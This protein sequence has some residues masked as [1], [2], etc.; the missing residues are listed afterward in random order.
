MRTIPLSVALLALACLARAG[1][2]AITLRAGLLLDGTGGRREMADVRVEGGRI[3][4]ITGPGKAV[5]THDLSG[6]T[7]LPGLIDAHDH[8]GWTFNDKGRLHT[9]DDG[10]SRER[11]ALGGAAN[12]WETLRSG[13]TTVQ[14]LGAP[15]DRDLRDAIAAGLPGPRILTSLEPLGEDTTVAPDALRALVR[16]RKAQGADVIKLF[17]SKSIRDG[18][19]A[20]LGDAQV[21]AVCG[22][23]KAVGLRSVVHAHAAD[24]MLAAARAGCTQVEHGVFATP[25]AL[26]EMAQRGTVFDP[27][28][29]LVFRN[30]LRHRAAYEGIGNYNAAGFALMETSIPISFIT[31]ARSS[32]CI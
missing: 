23:A 6:Y 18:G 20:S 9:E 5:P 21:E 19:G 11:V 24:A 1:D 13:F 25:E 4:A 10:E 15:E 32:W 27:Q 29:A 14:S 30:Y 17:A 8:I 31:L 28:C 22:E 26:R 7:L 2:P 16:E 12:A 3:T